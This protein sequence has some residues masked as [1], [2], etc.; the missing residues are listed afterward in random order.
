MFHDCVSNMA[1]AMRTVGYLS[2]E[3]AENND[4]VK[5]TAGS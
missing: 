5:Q 3:T 2:R 1:V 4:I